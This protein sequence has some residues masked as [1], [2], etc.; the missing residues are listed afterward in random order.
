METADANRLMIILAMATPVLAVLVLAVGGHAARLAEEPMPAR[1][2]RN[3]WILA[4]AGPA[5]LALW[6]I[7]N[8]WLNFIGHRSAAGYIIAGLTFI[9]AG[10]GT[11][12][13]GRL[14]EKANRQDAEDT[15]R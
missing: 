2:R 6:W 10:F 7:F 11:G 9:G 1:T 3:A 13:F 5:T 8:H 12:F 15:H 4:F 14:R